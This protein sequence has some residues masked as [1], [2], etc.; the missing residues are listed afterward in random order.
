MSKAEKWKTQSRELDR[1]LE[2][3]CLSDLLVVSLQLLQYFGRAAVLDLFRHRVELADVLLVRAHQIAQ[4]VC[5][6]LRCGAQLGNRLINDSRIRSDCVTAGV[7]LG[8]HLS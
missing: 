8:D 5:R 4:L 1:R 3:D 7:E 6:H 2:A